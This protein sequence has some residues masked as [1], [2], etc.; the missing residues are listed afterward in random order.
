MTGHSAE[1]LGLML[2][3]PRFLGP[4]AAGELFPP[5][6]ALSRLAES[7][8]AERLWVS[9]LSSRVTVSL[10]AES[11]GAL[12]NQNGPGR[13]E[14]RLHLP[15]L[16]QVLLLLYRA[17]GGVA[18]AEQDGGEKCD[19][20]GRAQ[21]GRGRGGTVHKPRF[22]GDAVAGWLDA[23]ICK[24]RAKPHFHLNPHRC[25]GHRASCRRVQ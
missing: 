22:K 11:A 13:P 25:T 9:R 1:S 18:A 21:G 4:P 10:A 20:D 24:A 14:R 16:L 6:F 17:S 15:V 8:S 7:L 12:R 3:S 2:N 23:S 5:A 19:N